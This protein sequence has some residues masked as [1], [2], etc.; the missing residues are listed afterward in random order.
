M[1]PRIQ[2]LME[3]RA[4]RVA[5]EHISHDFRPQLSLTPFEPGAPCSKTHFDQSVWQCAHP[6][7]QPVVSLLSFVRCPTYRRQLHSSLEHFSGVGMM[8]FVFFLATLESSQLIMTRMMIYLVHNKHIPRMSDFAYRN[9]PSVKHNDICW[10]C[11]LLPGR[12]RI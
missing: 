10:R 4:T 9:I 5:S 11:A 7:R 8:L 2:E 1:R 3:S 6:P 12:L